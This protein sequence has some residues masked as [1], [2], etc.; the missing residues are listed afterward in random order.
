MSGPYHSERG[1]EAKIRKTFM[2]RELS[3]VEAKLSVELRLDLAPSMM[4][5]QAS[6][7]GGAEADFKA[8]P[9]GL[10]YLRDVD[11][12]RDMSARFPPESQGNGRPGMGNEVQF[13]Q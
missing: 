2:R 4:G 6:P 11:V 13:D 9:Y 5:S 1:A 8:Q 10:A 3:G 7:R 12:E